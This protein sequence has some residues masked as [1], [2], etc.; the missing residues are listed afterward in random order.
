M[1]FRNFTPHAIALAKADGST[2]I[3][4]PHYPA[5][6]VITTPHPMEE[7][8]DGIA[9]RGPGLFDSIQGLPDKAPDTLIIV[10]QITALMVAATMSDRDDVVYPATGAA[11]GGFRDANGTLGVRRL[12]RAM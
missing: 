2:H 12:I 9:I 11:E 1:I 8:C 4:E 6:R 7:D 5:A 3:L 10:S